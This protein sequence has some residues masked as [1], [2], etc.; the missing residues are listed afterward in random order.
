MSEHVILVVD[1]KPNMLTLLTKVLRPLG[2]VR[3]ATSAAEALAFVRSEKP[4]V[5][6]CDLR[7]PD[8]DGLAVLRKV[9]AF[10][11]ATPFILMTAY[12]TISTAIQAIREGAFDYVTKPFDPEAVR[13]LVARALGAP[14][15]QDVVSRT[16]DDEALAPE[17]ASMDERLVDLSLREALAAS[18]HVT[19]KRYVMAVL[20]RFRGD[21]AAAADHADIERESFYRLMRRYGLSASEFRKSGGQD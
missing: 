10:A 18:R 11:P 15:A 17:D 16:T 4:D 12:A 19:S 2:R 14:G 1:D 21:V 8:E 7:L 6:L 20:R 5:V 13:T 9:H 3:T